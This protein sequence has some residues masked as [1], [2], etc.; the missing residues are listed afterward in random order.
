VRG[1]VGSQEAAPRAGRPATPRAPLDNV[2]PGKDQHDPHLFEATILQE[3]GRVA[4]SLVRFD[5]TFT[6]IM[7]VIARVVDYTIGAMAFVEDE[8]LDVV[9][10]LRRP[11]APAAVEEAKARLLE[12]VARHRQPG[13]SFATVQ[14]R[15]FAPGG[16][17][18]QEPVEQA[19]SGF[20]C[21]PVTTNGRLTGL[22]ALG[23]KQAA[24][25]GAD[26]GKF[27]A[28]AANLAH[29]VAVNSRLFDRLRNLSVRDGL[30][31]LYNHRHSVEL[32][33]HEFERVVRYEG[34]VSVLMIDIDH[35]KRVNDVHGHPAGDGVLREASRVIKDT[36]RSVDA[37][38]RYGGEEFLAILPHT[39]AEEAR[40]TAERVRRAVD[41]H[42][43]RAGGREL[44]I[45]VS[46]GTA[47]HP[48]DGVDSPAA[49][50]RKADA[51]L[52]KAKEA[53]RNR[54][55]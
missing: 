39:G 45:T 42:T 15:L 35:F 36:L 28:D 43:F 24:R 29:I 27:L 37:L 12:A 17:A 16:D 40:Q 25:I 22:L 9:L 48:Q 32:L 53:G 13:E 3:I 20:A 55:A 21:F 1:I 52:Y 19:L 38:G 6:S 8:D 54:V 46:V 18:A 23:G 14:A 5:E 31:D 7:A 10:V 26:T 51:A 41:G 4:R 34:G 44:R 2:A 50:I 49:L 47:S 11:A 33:A 30:T